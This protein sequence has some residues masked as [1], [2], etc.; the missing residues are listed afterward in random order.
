M[1]WRDWAKVVGVLLICVGLVCLAQQGRTQSQIPLMG[2]GHG[3]VAASS[4]CSQA[5]TA[6][7]RLDGGQ[8]TTAIT[9][10]ICGMVTDGTY[11][12]LD[13]LWLFAINS[14]GNAETNL[15]T[16]S[17]YNITVTGG[18]SL[19]FTSNTGISNNA[20]A[21]GNTNFN[22]NTAGGNFT[23]NSASIGVCDVTSRTSG[24]SSATMMGAYDGTNYVYV[25]PLNGA[26]NII[27]DLNEANF[28]SASNT[29]A[30]GSYI[31]SR[32]TSTLITAYFNGSS[33]GTNTSS[34]GALVNANVYVTAYN[35][36]G[37]AAQFL[38]DYLGY[39]F[40]GGGLTGT[41]ASNL[42]SRLH[43]YMNTVSPGSGC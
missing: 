22:P 18:S 20:A 34:S 2:V 11:S 38:S 23:L 7:A 41:Q 17:S 15:A 14:V 24:S 43:T 35:N 8:N 39:A 21:V 28:P 9:T 16:S 37:T 33:V 29:N 13:G 42:Y 3:P 5:T 6:N 27:Y 40:I 31:I 36:N 25:Q 12:L 1:R 32:T 26:D 19:S 4:G 10:L 30:N